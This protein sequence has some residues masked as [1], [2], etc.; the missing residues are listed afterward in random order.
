M[1]LQLTDD[2]KLAV[3]A[4]FAASSREN[5]ADAYRA[6]CAPGAVTWH[7][8]DDA[9]VTTDQTVK[10]VGW[11]HRTVPDTTAQPLTLL[12]V[13]EDFTVI[14]IGPSGGA[15]VS[16]ALALRPNGSFGSNA[17]RSHMPGAVPQSTQPLAVAI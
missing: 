3:A 13:P 9:E 7:N 2:E 1:T 4:R 16:D 14:V 10:T 15:N 8:F 6:L 5:D 17:T 11:L 12:T